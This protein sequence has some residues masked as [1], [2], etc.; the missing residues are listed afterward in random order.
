LRLKLH[1]DSKKKG[2]CS[3]VVDV[4]N[5]KNLARRATMVKGAGEMKWLGMEIYI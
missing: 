4:G 1:A 2:Q 5:G 3:V